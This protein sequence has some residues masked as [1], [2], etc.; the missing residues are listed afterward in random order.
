MM[1]YSQVALPITVKAYL[2]A[3]NSFDVDRMLAYISPEIVF[4]H[5]TAGEITH[6]TADADQ[7]ADLARSAVTMFAE[8]K[9]EVLSA[10][11][12]GDRTTLHIEYM[13]E[14]MA[15]VAIDLPNGWRAGQRIDLKGVSLFRLE[16]DLIIE[17]I[18]VV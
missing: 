13:A 9:Q 18:D 10:I 5:L 4:L 17:I 6:R 7:C 1:N 11:I 3:Y 8:R 2:D 12:D 14:Y 15:H 16:Q